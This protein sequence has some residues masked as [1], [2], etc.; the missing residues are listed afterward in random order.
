M[1]RD[2]LSN[3]HLFGYTRPMAALGSYQT[4]LFAQGEPAVVA[5]AAVQRTTL[6]ET[7][8][9]DVSRN[10][11]DGADRLLERLADELEWRGGSRPMYGRMVDEPRLH[12]GLDARDPARAD[13]IDTMT[14]WLAA[15]YG[16]PINANF[17]NYYRTGADSVAWHADRISLER[18]DPVVAICSLGG[19]RRFGLRPM[20]GGPS[21]RFTL[22]SG[23]LLVMGGACQRAWEHCVPKM[24]FAA[25]R[26]SLTFRHVD[27]VAGDD[28]WYSREPILPVPAR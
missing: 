23:D 25:P 27:D 13:L 22:G 17:V 28:W 4:T 19:P 11:L 12:A 7:S 2:R 5:D 6:D 8:W 20:A 26:M 21:H 10:W 1:M 15:R 24:A 9:V 14:R 18:L 16:G 3:E